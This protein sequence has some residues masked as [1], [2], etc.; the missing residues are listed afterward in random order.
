MQKS[1]ILFSFS[2]GVVTDGI[3]EWS[4]LLNAQDV[5]EL[6]LFVFKAAVSGLISLAVTYLGHRLITK[7]ETND[8][9]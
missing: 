6:S 1:G 9:K 2:A 7:K 3:S 5:K 8:P 4:Q